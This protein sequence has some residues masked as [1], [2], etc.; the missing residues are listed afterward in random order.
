MIRYYK[1]IDQKVI[2]LKTEDDA[3]WINI[4]P[5]FAQ[6]ELEQFS[7][8]F[9]FPLDF[10]MDSLDIDER[11]RYE[12]E[13][14][15]NLILFNTPLL[16]EDMKENEA[17]YYTA[18]VGIVLVVDKIV[19]VTSRENPIIDKFLDN[20]VKNFDPSD[21]KLFVLQLFE[22]NVLGF[23]DCLKKLNL[24]R[25]II[26]QELYNSSRN[27]ELQ[28][29]LRIEKSLVYFVNSL[30]ANELLKMKM[31]RTDLLNIRDLE[32]HAD[33]FEDVLIDNSQ[34]LEMSNVH[35]NILS[36]TMETYAS[37][38]SNNMNAFINRLTVITI[39]L[40]VPT[41]VYSFFGMNIYIP[42]TG[43]EFKYTYLWVILFSIFFVAG[44]IIF[45][46]KNR[47]F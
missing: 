21:A 18:P 24:K 35:T 33:L 4:S 23:L 43:D 7:E 38:V 47:R 31:K 25:N 44:L 42:G 32:Y 22:Q 10:L 28:Q 12:R 17:M 40:M 29:L 34:A 37:I 19:T 41:L 30:S 8:S 39:T 20:K 9:D 6:G 46:T 11:S 45:M 36:G 27:K 16:N 15:A 1:K 26:E 3:T 13:E 14:N 5:P 2:E